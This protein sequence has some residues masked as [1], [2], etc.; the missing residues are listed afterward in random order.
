MGSIASPQFYVYVL[1]RPNGKPF[2]VGKG[3]GERI[4]KHD[5][6]AR[7]GHRCHKCNVIRKIWREGGQVQRYIALETDDEQEAY[8]YE[9]ELIAMYGR[10]TLCNRSDGGEGPSGVKHTAEVRRKQSAA[11]LARF[12]RTEE[13]AKH[14]ATL[15]AYFAQ[16]G[17]REKV[18]AATKAFYARQEPRSV[19]CQ[20]CKSTFQSVF[21]I[22]VKYCSARCK[23]VAYR[24][25]KAATKA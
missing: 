24:R 19:V 25:R 23:A 8:A 13:R 7:S 6:E 20:V 9:R 15:K 14:S 21:Q 10:Q 4:F 22:P 3:Q 16:P 2:Y 1:C 11:Q 18:S 12:A 17:S 5:V